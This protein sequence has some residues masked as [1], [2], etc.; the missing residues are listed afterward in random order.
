MFLSMAAFAA[1]ITPVLS[2]PAPLVE[3]NTDMMTAASP[4]MKRSFAGPAEKCYTDVKKKCDDIST[5]S[6]FSF[7]LRIL[8][9]LL[10]SILSSKVPMVA[11]R[12]GWI[13]AKIDASVDAKIDADVAVAVI[14]DLHIIADLIAKLGADLTVYIKGGA[15]VVADVKACATAV[16]AIVNLCAS[17][18]VKVHASLLAKVSVTVFATVLVKLG[19]AVKVVVDLLLSVCLGKA[20]GLLAVDLLLLVDLVAKLTACLSAFVTACLALGVSV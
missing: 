4:V 7:S 5:S 8:L 13:A 20:G 18:L 10:H 1:C 11:D 6:S 14:A 16:V 15:L 19:A 3:S 17:V 2:A 12:Y 9:F